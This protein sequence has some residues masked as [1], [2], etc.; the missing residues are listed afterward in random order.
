[1]KVEDKS[2]RLSS[3]SV[4]NKVRDMRSPREIER[5]RMEE[6]KR[7]K[8]KMERRGSGGFFDLDSDD[9]KSPDSPK[10][11]N[12]KSNNEKKEESAFDESNYLN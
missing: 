3:S 12:P 7:L 4:D 11:V 2:S 6:E 1:M 5:E 8:R 9:E 10:S